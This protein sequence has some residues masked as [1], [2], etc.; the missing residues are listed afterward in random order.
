MKETIVIKIGGNATN[1][2]PQT[3]FDQIKEW[4][5]QGKKILIIHGG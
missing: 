5:K 2:L 1:Q 3:F 4:W